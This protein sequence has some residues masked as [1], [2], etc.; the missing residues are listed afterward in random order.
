M[1]TILCNLKGSRKLSV[2]ETHLNTIEHY[3]LFSDLLDSNGI[4]E[5]SVL[6]KLRLNVRSLLSNGEPDPQLVDLCEQVI[7]HSDMKAFGLHQLILLFIDW[8]KEKL[9]A[10]K[11]SLKTE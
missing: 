3:A 6:E 4:V 10:L 5:E 9:D 2:S 1:Y 8:E 7:F 11:E